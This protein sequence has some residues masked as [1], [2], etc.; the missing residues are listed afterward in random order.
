MSKLLTF[1]ALFATT[2]AQASELAG[3]AA[4]NADMRY[5]AAGMQRDAKD[6]Q[7]V[8]GLMSLPLGDRWWSQFGGGQ[9]R[10]EQEANARR[11][12]VLNAG[13][14]Y[15]GSGWLASLA[16]SRRSAGSSLR[17]ADWNGLLEWR[18]EQFDVGVDGHYRDAR[19]SGT[20]ATPT[21]PSG[22]ADVPVLQRVKGS[23]IGVHGNIRVTENF[24]VH[25]AAMRFDYRVT[26]QQTGSGAGGGQSL[27][28][29]ALQQTSPSLVSREEAALN[30]SSKVGASYRFEKVTLSGE[31]LADRVLD[32]PGTVRT[33]QLKA[34]LE[35]TP[36]W[37]A[38]PTVGRT[39]SETYGGV[40]FGGLVVS[41]AW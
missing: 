7:A 36:H 18:G 25:A 29:G 26:T 38:T 12:S 1:V 2:L 13:F 24:S 32:E 17:Q 33:V 15:I 22:T 31:V 30:R 41:Y 19:L 11:A 34:A 23:G 20:V 5:V 6:N 35:L 40:N 37:T 10:S 28:L 8:T 39:E 21:L 14:G 16:A 27:L 3:T 9:T 4:P